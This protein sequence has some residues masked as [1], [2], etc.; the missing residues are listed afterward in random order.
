M[1]RPVPHLVTSVDGF[2]QYVSAN[3]IVRG[4]VFVVAGRIPDGKDAERI[5]RKLIARFSANQSKWHRAANKRAGV[6]STRYLRYDRDWFLFAT[7]G[8]HRLFE[9]E[10]PRNLR[11]T[12]LRFYGYSI[13]LR[14]GRG[15]VRIDAGQ[16]RLLRDYFVE[17]APK[18]DVAWLERELGRLPFRGYAPVRRQLFAILKRVNHAR[19]RAGCEILSYRCLP[20]RRPVVRPFD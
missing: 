10:R 12:P 19:L 20:L 2:V 6:A 8:R 1:T 7:P 9:D 17:M 5:D 16:Y 14:N 3:V 4:Y 13:G 15:S 11:R 18:R